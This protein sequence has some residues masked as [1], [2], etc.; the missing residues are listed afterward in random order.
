MQRYVDKGYRGRYAQNPRR[1]FISG[2]KSGVSG[3][4][5]ANRDADP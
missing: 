1:A 3:V 5:E 4:I 2:R